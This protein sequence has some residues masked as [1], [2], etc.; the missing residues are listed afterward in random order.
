MTAQADLADDLQHFLSS[1]PIR[2]RLAGP[3]ERAIEWVRRRP[4]AAALGV[5]AVVALLSLAAVFAQHLH[6]RA[7]QA[8]Q[9]LNQRERI[10]RSWRDGRESAR[11]GDWHNARLQFDIAL[12][13]IGLDPW[14]TSLRTEIESSRRRRPIAS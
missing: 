3:W 11:K 2:A 8:E 1:E 4:A 14:L 10:D 7:I 13:N 12:A 6:H 5:A 9:K